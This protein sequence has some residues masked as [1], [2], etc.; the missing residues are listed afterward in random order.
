M[1]NFICSNDYQVLQAALYCKE[2]QKPVC[3]FFLSDESGS[4]NP[5]EDITFVYVN[6]DILNTPLKELT[7][8]TDSDLALLS[9]IYDDEAELHVFENIEQ[10][11][12]KG[13]DN[14]I[15]HDNG[16]TSYILNEFGLPGNLDP[17][18]VSKV[19]YKQSI[20]DIRSDKIFDCNINKYKE[21]LLPIFHNAKGIDNDISDNTI[22]FVHNTPDDKYTQEEKEEIYKELEFLLQDIKKA[23]YNI[24]FK[25]HHKRKDNHS[26]SDIVDQVI[27]D[28][29]VELIPNLDKYKYIVSVRNNFLQY[30]Q[31]DNVVN[32]LTQ[33]AV[34][35]CKKN[36]KYVYSRGIFKIRKRLNLLDL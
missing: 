17:Y 34:T 9:I 23:G 16:D 30:L 31:N 10:L 27:Q 24:H 22:L 20:D 5:I 28:V 1:I 36:W 3:I 35:K 4:Y 12:N 6:K 32:A 11:Y 33:E 19:L 25:E 2:F 7:Q 21:E 18:T 26:L 13:R 14:V 15:L 8:A 29:P